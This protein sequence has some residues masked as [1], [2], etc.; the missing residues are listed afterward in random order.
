MSAALPSAMAPVLQGA[1]LCAL[2][3]LSWLIAAQDARRLHLPGLPLA[4]IAGLGILHAIFLPFPGLS[5]FDSL[6]GGPFFFLVLSFYR[7]GLSWRLGREALGLGDV[8]LAGAGGFWIGWQ[9]AGPALLIACLLGLAFFAWRAWRRRRKGLRPPRVFAF[10][11]AL[12][13]AIFIVALAEA[14]G[15]VGSFARMIF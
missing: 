5:S 3:A 7:T 4:C 12:A 15:V 10:G 6:L 13:L 8:K 14:T 1:S 11:P 2:L 9:G